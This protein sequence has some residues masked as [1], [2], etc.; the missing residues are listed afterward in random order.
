MADPYLLR[1]FRPF[2]DSVTQDSRQEQVE[3]VAVRSGTAV[4]VIPTYNEA[5]NVEAVIRRA[6]EVSDRI[7]VL[8]VDDGSPDGT[9]DVVEGMMGQFPGKIGLLRR[10]EKL[11]LGTAY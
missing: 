10:S 11:G 8:V 1:L 7:S 9:A 5:K 6:L 3:A 2:A 4:V